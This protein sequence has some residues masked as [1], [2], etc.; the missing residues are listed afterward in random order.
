[1]ERQVTSGIGGRILTNCNV[2]SPDSRWIVYDT[3]SDAAGAVFDGTAIEI[4]NVETG[5]IRRV[6]ESRNEAC[7]GAATFH[8]KEN[9]VAFILGPEHPAPDWEYAPAHRQGVLVNVDEPG[10]A[11]NLDA[12]DVTPPFTPG[13]LRG[14]S[15]VHVFR[16]DGQALSFTYNDAPLSRF[17]EAT[18]E[19]ENDRRNIGVS[20][21]IG[22][23][24]VPKTHLRNH[25]GAYFS[26]LATR[27]TAN[28]RPGSDEIAQALE[29]GWI[30]TTGYV[31]PDGTRQ[32]AA[33]VFQ[34][35]VLAAN[36]NLLWEVFI[37][38]LP[39]DLTRAPFDGKLEG[40]ETRRPLPP[41]G[42]RQRRLTR[43]EDRRHPGIFGPRHWL[44]SS[45][46]GKE[47]AFL[48]RDDEGI[49]QIWT[50]SPNGGEP[51]QITSENWGVTS[52]FTWSPDGGLIAYIADNSV[53]TV[54]FRTG[55]SQR[56]TERT[57][58]TPLPLA[59][60]FSP[61]GT[62][63]AYL[64]RIEGANQIFVL[65]CDACDYEDRL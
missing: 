44:R 48:M 31:R 49:V 19:H 52:A 28:P 62:K 13:A 43:T 35:Q 37:V 42:T 1:M 46:G 34:G 61:D 15:H 55:Q 53:F 6:Y 25:N 56:R 17:E 29:E 21:P 26:V 20:V 54:D 8:P 11:L 23:V 50:V 4:A 24:S 47:I 27:T 10:V 59:C 2:W 58:E 14:G 12:R 39:E 65:H 16:P 36:G 18:A 41:L 7:C 5:K 33:L 45:P 32:I 3:R 64:R 40:T 57:A 38:D 9:W 30:G 51:R 60:V 22:A 63:I